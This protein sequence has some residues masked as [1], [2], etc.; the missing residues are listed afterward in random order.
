M[1]SSAAVIPFT[2]TACYRAAAAFL[3]SAHGSGTSRISNGRS[4]LTY[5]TYFDLTEANG[6]WASAGQVD[7]Y[8]PMLDCVGSVALTGIELAPGAHHKDITEVRPTVGGQ[9][10][11]LTSVKDHESERD[12]GLHRRWGFGG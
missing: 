1:T 6:L 11:I 5:R 7:A 8:G 2:P 3:N 12:K 9:S 10:L 4:T